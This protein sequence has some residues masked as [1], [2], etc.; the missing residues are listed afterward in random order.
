LEGGT[1]WDLG[2]FTTL[3]LIDL[4]VVF[5]ITLASFAGEIAFVSKGQAGLAQRAAIRQTPQFRI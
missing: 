4:T 1:E 5:C 3:T 2:M